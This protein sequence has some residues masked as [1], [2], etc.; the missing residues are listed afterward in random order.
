MVK[1]LACFLTQLVKQL[2]HDLDDF[3]NQAL[4]LLFIMYN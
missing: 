2:D 1:Q 4:F 3:F